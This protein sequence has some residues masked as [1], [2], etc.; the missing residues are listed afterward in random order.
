MREKEKCR[1]GNVQYFCMYTAGFLAVALLLLLIFA[2]EHASFTKMADGVAQ[3]YAVLM[4]I[5]NTLRQFLHGNFA[6]PMVDFSVGQGFD[7]I[8]T[9]NYYGVGDPVNL[10]TVFFADNHLDQMY[11]FLILFRMYLSGL[12]FSYYCSFQYTRYR[13]GCARQCRYRR[14][15]RGSAPSRC[16]RGGPAGAPDSAGSPP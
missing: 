2:K 12:T 5:R 6:L 9:L 10:L 13:S 8:G 3:H 4:W 14:A 15:G 16:S 11:M 1:K 7:V